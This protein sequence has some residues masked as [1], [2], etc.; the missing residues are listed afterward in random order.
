MMRATDTAASGFIPMSD[1]HHY[2]QGKATEGASSRW[3]DVYN[4]ATGEKSR[5]VAFAGAGEVDRAVQA[6]AA[7]AVL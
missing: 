4:P 5:R 3:G 2:I 7:A 1:V 6:A